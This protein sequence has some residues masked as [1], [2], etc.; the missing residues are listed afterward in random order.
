MKSNNAE[1]RH[2]LIIEMLSPGKTISVDN[3]C[4]AFQCSPSTIRNDLNY[5]AEQKRI[6]R[7]FGGA[8]GLPS[9]VSVLYTDTL[10][11]VE[12]LHNCQE[13][14]A[15]AV[16]HLIT[17]HTT[18]ILDSS[19]TTLEIARLLAKKE[20]PVSVL[21]FSLSII[22]TLANVPS[23]NLYSFGGF[24]NMNRGAFFDDYIADHT[25]YLHA[26]TYF[27]QAS[28]VSPEAGFTISCQDVPV[29]E[30]AL[31][32]MAT[33]TI[34]LCDSSN[35]C[36]SACRIIADLSLINTMVTDSNANTEHVQKLENAGLNVLIS[37]KL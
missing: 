28:S 4:Q 13:I 14:A 25:R 20:I 29:T 21:T 11:P 5:L 36:K 37:E 33:K 27:M 7:T 23:I 16:E 8:K 2:N 22:N 3:F 30:T 34:A 18:I 10:S 6:I 15:Y 24:Y 17:P 32:K 26:D 1:K 9:S 31:M 35:L 19:D 12:I